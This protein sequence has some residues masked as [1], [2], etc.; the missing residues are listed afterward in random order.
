MQREI[1]VRLRRKLRKF[2]ELAT[3]VETIAESC[4]RNRTVVLWLHVKS[5][6]QL[7]RA[8]IA[9]KLEGVFF[10]PFFY[11]PA[12]RYDGRTGCVCAGGGW[13]SG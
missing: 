9:A 4:C 7:K 12:E 6:S 10:K 2:P 8:L 11:E 1:A 5:F 13:S 3:H